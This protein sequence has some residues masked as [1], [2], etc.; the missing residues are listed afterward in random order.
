MPPHERGEEIPVWT[1]A[2]AAIT[3]SAHRGRHFAGRNVETDL[4]DRIR[5]LCAKV[6]A[7]PEAELE[8]VIVELQSALQE[9]LQELRL[10]VAERFGLTGKDDE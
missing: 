7:A 3:L 5:Q 6:V 8:P 10:L 4:A 1:N 9:H 2:I